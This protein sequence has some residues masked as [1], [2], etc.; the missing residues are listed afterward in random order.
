[1]SDRP[2]DRARRWPVT[3][4]ELR[5]ATRA[6]RPSLGEKTHM[7]PSQDAVRRDG[8]ADLRKAAAARRSRT[9]EMTH[10]SEAKC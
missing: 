7:R 9:T 8:L 6:F 4:T 2:P 5:D 1:M 3:A 10:G